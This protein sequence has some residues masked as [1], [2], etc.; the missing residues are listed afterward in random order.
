LSLSATYEKVL[1]GLSQQCIQVA[2][3][4]LETLNSIRRQP[5]EE[6]CHSGSENSVEVLPELINFSGSIDL[7]T[8]ILHRHHEVV[9]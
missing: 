9:Y 6:K 8:G 7:Q 4:L 1:D 3:E 2:D 5:N